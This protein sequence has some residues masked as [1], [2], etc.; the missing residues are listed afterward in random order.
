MGDR[1]FEHPGEGILARGA[2]DD[3][4]AAQAPRS[5]GYDLGFPSDLDVHGV[6]HARA[7]EHLAGR[8]R[9]H[10]C[11]VVAGTYRGWLLPKVR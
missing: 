1:G 8:T 5:F 11:F 6:R 9:G 3:V 10:L 2:H 4:I 7:V